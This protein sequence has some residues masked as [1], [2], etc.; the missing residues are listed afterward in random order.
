MLQVAVVPGPKTEDLGSFM[1]PMLDDLQQLA[2]NGINV[3]LDDGRIQK[4]KAY[5]L[6]CGGDIP[7][8]AKVSGV[9]HHRA[10]RGCRFCT[11][12]GKSFGRSMVFEPEDPDERQPIR[13]VGSYKKVDWEAGQR[14]VTLFADL[15]TFHG[16]SFFPMDIMHMLGQGIAKQFWALISDDKYN[17]EENS[18]PLSLPVVQCKTIG[19]EVAN[20]RSLSK[21]FSRDCGNVYTRSGYYRAIDWLHFMMYLVPTIVAR[22]F[23]GETRNAILQLIHVYHIACKRELTEDDVMLMEISVNHWLQWLKEQVNAKRTSSKIFTIN[24]HYL[25]H[26]HQIAK[27]LGPLP[28]YASFSMERAIGD[29]KKHINSKRDPGTNAHNVMIHLAAIR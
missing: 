29:I 18:N 4:V 25:I 17:G 3:K 28:V 2:N 23:D 5:L 15:P 20:C 12:I 13:G 6:F 11:I 24:Q 27:H 1:K 21:D 7:A 22:Y 14:Q 8:V 10:K 26:L 19:V 9:S 16:A